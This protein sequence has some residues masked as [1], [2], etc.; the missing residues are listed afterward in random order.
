MIVQVVPT[1]ARLVRCSSLELVFS[2]PTSQ[3]VTRATGNGRQV[4]L[5][6]S[7]G[8]VIYLEV[9]AEDQVLKQVAIVKL[10]Q[11]IACLSLQ[12]LV[13]VRNE[14]SMD[15]VAETDDSMGTGT[16]GND[17]S[18]FLAVGM[19]TDG[20]VRLLALP[21][22]QELTR[23]QLIADTQT[24]ARDV[25]IAALGDPPNK[26]NSAGAGSGSSGHTAFQQYLMVGLG[27]GTLITYAIDFA[28]GLPT[29]G[30][31]R[32]VVMGT[33]PITLS[34]FSNAGAPCVFASCDRPTVVHAR[35]GKLIFSVVNIP[36]V[37]NMAPFHSELF[38]DCLALSSEAG[39]T[40]GTVDEI[41][42][43]HIQTFPLGES[44]NRIAHSTQCGI[45]AGT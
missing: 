7:G 24:Q 3:T 40:I 14:G 30:S 25:L 17:K 23:M 26:S 45:Y 18:T 36:E 16:A 39:L 29:L 44:P 11:D 41:Q 1:G 37:S 22:L 12:P 35:S 31:K 10:D 4:V 33:H 15:L 34:L 42:K 21:T 2:F 5:G 43:L 13:D 27:D 38:P 6:L 20:T 8:E 19:W 32:K 9:S 28:S